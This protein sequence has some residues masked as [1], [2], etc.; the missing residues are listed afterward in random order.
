MVHDVSVRQGAECAGKADM[1]TTA[2]LSP[3]EKFKRMMEGGEA[4]PAEF[5]A[6]VIASVTAAP[7]P[8]PEKDALK[9]QLAELQAAQAAQAATFRAETISRDAAA[10][11]DGEVAAGRAY[12]AEREAIIALFSAAAEDDATHGQAS[13]SNGAKGSRVD[14]LKAAYAQRPPHGLTRELLAQTVNAGG[15]TALPNQA[16]TEFSNADKPVT[17]ERREQLLRLTAI[18]REVLASE[19]K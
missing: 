5:T 13:F 14:A 18:G 9:Q 2:P 12:P 17:P 4:A 3:W 10:F 16:T 15:A 11:A 6:P 1:S 8:D 7:A 19:K